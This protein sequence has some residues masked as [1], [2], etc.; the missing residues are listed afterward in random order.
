[1]GITEANRPHQWWFLTE[2][3]ELFG[4]HEG[5]GVML[6][7]ALPRTRWLG[8]VLWVL[9]MSSLV[10]R[11][12]WWVTHHRSTFSKWV[13]DGPALYRDQIGQDFYLTINRH[14]SE[15]EQWMHALR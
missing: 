14:T 12:S 4:G 3:G 7:L 13:D 11:F 10:D 1:M 9:R 8:R 15:A 2:D 5:G 6:L